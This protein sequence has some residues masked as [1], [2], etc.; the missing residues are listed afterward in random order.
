M[1]DFGERLLR[2]YNRQ[3]GYDSVFTFE[4]CNVWRVPNQDSNLLGLVTINVNNIFKIK[5]VQV[6]ADGGV[7][8]PKDRNHAGRRYSFIEFV[9]DVERGKVEQICRQAMAELTGRHVPRADDEWDE[10]DNEDGEHDGGDD[11]MVFMDEATE[12]QANLWNTPPQAEERLD[13]GGQTAPAPMPTPE[14][15]EDMPADQLQEMLA[16]DPMRFAEYM[17]RMRG[18]EICSTLPLSTSPTN[19][20]KL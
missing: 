6:H 2:K 18:R 17:S 16:Q 9:G 4:I 15:I 5:R 12:I 1:E 11:P 13:R 10:D 19:S 20:M 3:G 8:F 14:Q 7:V